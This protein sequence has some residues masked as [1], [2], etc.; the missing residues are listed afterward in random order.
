VMKHQRKL[1][2]A[3]QLVSELEI[4]NDAVVRIDFSESSTM[5]LKP[6]DLFKTNLSLTSNVAIESIWR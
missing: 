1:N 4:T 6:T 3:L 5:K 2:L